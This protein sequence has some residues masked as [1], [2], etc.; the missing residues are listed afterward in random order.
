MDIVTSNLRIECSNSNVHPHNLNTW[1]SI[2][3]VGS[4]CQLECSYVNSLIHLQARPPCCM[5]CTSLCLGAFHVSKHDL[6]C[7]MLHKLTHLCRVCTMSSV[8]L[9]GPKHDM[10]PPFLISAKIMHPI[11]MLLVIKKVWRDENGG[12]VTRKVRC[13]V[14]FWAPK[15]KQVISSP[16]YHAS[17]LNYIVV[18]KLWLSLKCNVTVRFSITR[19]VISTCC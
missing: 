13:G 17:K 5:A 16:Q 3:K 1:V 18:L 9:S 6:K 7:R 14:G 4:D 8:S 12:V 19:G 11:G 2:I 10:W 15:Q